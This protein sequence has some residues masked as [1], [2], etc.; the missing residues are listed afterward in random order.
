VIDLQ[1]SVDR[2]KA[3]IQTVGEKGALFPCAMGL[4]NIPLPID[5]T[6]L[7]NF[8]ISILGPEFSTEIA[9]PKLH[10]EN[11]S[12][13]GF[14]V[15]QTTSF[16]IARLAPFLRTRLSAHRAMMNRGYTWLGGTT[17]L[18][19]RVT[20]LTSGLQV[21]YTHEYYLRPNYMFAGGAPTTPVDGDIKP[22]RWHFGTSQGN[23]PVTFDLNKVYDVPIVS[24][25]HLQV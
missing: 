24:Q 19:F 7:P 4:G 14:P 13:E 20:T 3:Q 21:H 22:G 17:V 8:D 15:E 25:A 5:P 6:A 18:A 10:V 11:L 12:I 2:F 23:G 9:T 1:P 16:F